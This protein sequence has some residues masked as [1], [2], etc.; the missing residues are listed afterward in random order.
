MV[1]RAAF[2]GLGVVFLL[3]LGACSPDSSSSSPPATSAPS[4]SPSTAPTPPVQS[5]TACSSPQVL[6]TVKEIVWDAVEDTVARELAQD[7]VADITASTK[8]HVKLSVEGAATVPGQNGARPTCEATLVGRADGPINLTG[9]WLRR[10]TEADPG[11]RARSTELSGAVTYVV[12]PSDDGKS[13]RVMADGVRSYALALAGLG[14]TFQTPEERSRFIAEHQQVNAA[15]A[16][17]TTSA[18]SA[19]ARVGGAGSAAQA[20]YAAADKA[21]N[22]AYQALRGRLGDAQKSA[23][24]DEQRAWV[25]RRDSECSEA[26]ITAA[27]KGGVA[28][29]SAMA[30]ELLGCKSRMTEDRTRELRAKG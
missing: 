7:R 4:Q 16:A 12:Q 27:S 14:M 22:E 13:T 9:T 18:G 6:E 15:P 3:G 23:L 20:E 25:K 29:G 2:V 10:A 1:I 17:P 5:P 30:L 8:A 11:L 21:L 28:G 26:R 19:A 24:R